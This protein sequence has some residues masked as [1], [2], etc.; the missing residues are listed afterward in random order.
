MKTKRYFFF[1]ILMS[2]LM[3][4]QAAYSS[5]PSILPLRERA[6]V[7]NRWLTIRLEEVLPEIMRREKFDMWIVICQEYNEDPVFKTLVPAT[8]FAARRLTM[9]VS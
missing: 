1:I 7:I 6:E 8:S 4:V 9:L 2:A 3:F 5:T